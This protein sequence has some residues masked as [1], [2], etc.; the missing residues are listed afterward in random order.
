MYAIPKNEYAERIAKFQANL[1]AAGLDAARKTYET[2][3]GRRADDDA[4][5]GDLMREALAIGRRR[6]RE[7][8]TALD[9]TR[10]LRE[11]LNARVK[12]LM[13]SQLAVPKDWRA[14]NAA[15]NRRMLAQLDQIE[16]SIQASAPNQRASAAAAELRRLFGL[17]KAQWTALEN[18]TRMDALGPATLLQAARKAIERDLRA[19]YRAEMT[20]LF[21]GRTVERR[22]PSGQTITVQSQGLARRG[23]RRMVPEQRQAME[24]LIEGIDFANLKDLPLDAMR[25]HVDRAREIL[26]EDALAKKAI[27]E[28]H[29]IR[30]E[31]AAEAAAAEV[32]AAR[33]A[34]AQAA[35]G[36]PEKGDML[37]RLGWFTASQNRRA[38]LLA[39]GNE[40]GAIGTVLWSNLLDAN[41]RQLTLEGGDLRAFDAKIAELGFT[42]RDMLDLSYQ[43]RE[44]ELADGRK[45]LMTRGE[46][47]TLYGM[48]LDEDARLKLVANGWIPARWRK[49]KG[50]DVE[51]IRGQGEDYDAR[52]AAS[53]AII[54]GVVAQLTPAEKAFVEWMV[55]DQSREWARR[56]N[57]TSRRMTGAELFEDK[58]HITLAGSIDREAV[59]PDVDHDDF[60]RGTHMVDNMGLTKERQAHSHALF[61]RDIFS[62]YRQQARD[63]SVYTAWSIP[64]RD[65]MTLL[66]RGPA[67][68][69]I[70]NRWGKDAVRT[71]KETLAYVTYQKGHTDNWTATQKWFYRRERAA[72]GFILGMQASSAMLNRYAGAL[73][74]AAAIESEGIAVAGARAR[75]LARVFRPQAGMA[76]L[77][78]RER[79]AAYDALMADGYLYDRWHRSP[80]RVFAQLASARME[81]EE[82][83]RVLRESRSL[84]RRDWWQ[85]FQQKALSFMTAGEI[86]NGVDLYLT[87]RSGGMSQADAVRTVS[88]LTR[89]TQNPS[90]PL[91]ETTQ[92]T[93]IRSGGLGFMMP[94]TGQPAVLWNYVKAEHI[95]ARRSGN[96][97]PFRAA[98]TGAVSATLFSV[99]LRMVL[100][101]ASKGLMDGDDDDEKELNRETANTIL[102]LAGEFSGAVMPG[103]DQLAQAFLRPAIAYALN[104]RSLASVP[105]GDSTLLSRVM[106]SGYRMWK[107]PWRVARG[108]AWTEE[109][110]EKLF[111][112]AHRL[113][114]MTTGLPTGGIEQAAR[115][116][117]G[118][119]GDPLGREPPEDPGPVRRRRL[120][121]PARRRR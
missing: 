38:L 83:G 21:G 118:L 30:R 9:L 89:L 26:A 1:Q 90:T 5:V 66:S 71:M 39:G 88:R 59:V 99:A 40:S 98:L 8:R 64:F 112:D 34:L 29:K 63:M 56:G 24:T 46:M 17:D 25:A 101:R 81:R 15:V 84:A 16:T 55:A 76:R 58:P 36:D 49:G 113:I 97:G 35:M 43:L 23:L 115:V 44:V 102:D 116:G 94:F 19:Y 77:G 48:T 72:A 120:V 54:G 104:D 91:D 68:S 110:V 12:R 95:K 11:A 4:T 45:I 117:L 37:Q 33:P 75:F 27:A 6:G 65:A 10:M 41:E 105:P 92:Y 18:E 100:R 109:Q 14:I 32:K 70:V 78:V 3:A 119:A 73:A 42:R 2:I 108:E 47:M 79:R 57:E 53:E 114:G 28:G 96:W 22:L 86:G 85:R 67:L 20:T 51:I 93:S 50:E 87:L 13:G 106:E 80:Y 103:G 69:A 60:A 111:I 121:P 82:A 52:L 31:E 74:M 7:S 107:V 61:V 62:I